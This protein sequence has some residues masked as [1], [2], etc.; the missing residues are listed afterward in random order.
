MIEHAKEAANHMHCVS[1][2]KH[3][4]IALHTYHDSVGHLPSEASPDSPSFY[5]RL[6]PFV[7]AADAADDDPIVIYLCPM[8]RNPKTAPGKRDY[9]YASSQGEQAVGISVLDAPIPV[10][11][12]EIQQGRGTS[13][14]LL[15]SHL[16]LDPDHYTGGDPTDLG[17]ATKNNSRSI[18]QPAKPDDDP[19]GSNR[20]IGGPH[21]GVLPSLFADAHVGNFFYTYPSFPQIWAYDNRDDCAP[22]P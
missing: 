13:Y 18:S 4:G 8:R 1:R 6:L 7:E 10:S 20:H 5:K 3:M 12:G 14:T 15:L 2:L 17:W 22:P 11:L 9:G 19:T 16:W 21:P